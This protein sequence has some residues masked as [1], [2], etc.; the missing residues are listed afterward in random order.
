MI[1]A[2]ATAP[3]ITDIRRKTT[4]RRVT[5]R[6]YGGLLN[7]VN[8]VDYSVRYLLKMNARDLEAARRTSVIRLLHELSGH[9]VDVAMARLRTKG[10]GQVGTA[11]AVLLRNLDYSGTS[12]TTLAARSNVTKQAMTRIARELNE[13]G[14]VRVTPD[15]GDRRAKIVT[16]S[17]KGDSLIADAMAIAQEIER[18]YA[19]IVGRRAVEQ[20]RSTLQ[21]LVPAFR[22]ARARERQR[23]ARQFHRRGTRR[24]RTH[25]E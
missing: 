10:H 13:R 12:L 6:F 8:Y 15:A 21:K 23:V 14:Y 16:F 2:H 7:F 18:D 4:P 9:T 1:G 5:R 11:H 17:A 19:A 25:A 20:M 24:R 3:A 22:A